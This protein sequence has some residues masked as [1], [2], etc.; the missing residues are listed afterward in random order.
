[1]IGFRRVRSLSIPLSDLLPDKVGQA[2]VEQHF[3]LEVRRTTYRSEASALAATAGK[4]FSHIPFG[5]RVEESQLVSGP[6]SSQAGDFEAVSVEERVRET[7]VIHVL[8][9]LGF[10]DDVLPVTDLN[11]EPCRP[12]QR[13]PGCEGTEGVA[14]F[15]SAGREQRFVAR[16]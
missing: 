12:S 3:R 11:G 2:V 5:R 4:R 15:E 10:E 1:M 13:F 7:T 6:D 8:K 9:A 16:R 14:R